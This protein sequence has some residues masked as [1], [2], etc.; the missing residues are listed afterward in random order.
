MGRARLARPTACPRCGAAGFAV[1][2]VVHCGGVN[3]IMIDYMRDHVMPA[4][5]SLL[6]EGMDSEDAR[7]MLL[8][9]GLQESRFDHRV[10]IGGPARGFWQ[11]EKGGGIRGVLGHHATKYHAMSACRHLRYFDADDEAYN[12]IAH[13]DV[14]ACVFARLLLWSLPQ[15]LPTSSD[16]GWDQYLAAWRPGKPHPETWAAFYAQ[17]KQ[18]GV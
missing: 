2:P 13:N 8:A 11:F 9:I 16:D 17:A 14:L 3:L 4:A 1:W 10:Q 5:F 6:P 7:V 12:A 18:L 15:P